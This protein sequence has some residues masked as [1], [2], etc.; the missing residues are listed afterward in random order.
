MPSLGQQLDIDRCPHC[1]VN[2]P[3][4]SLHN[5]LNLAGRSGVSRHW[6]IY[7]CQKCAGVIIAEA[8]SERGSIK[9]IFPS[10]EQIDDSIPQ[11]ARSYLS[12]S[13]DSLHAPAGAIMLAA[14][15]V[16][17]ML[18]EKNYKAGNLY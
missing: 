18:K 1:G 4:V 13:R 5:Y 12:Q 3:N 8:V 9:A 2:S 15:A 6:G 17:A 11:R 14:S 7:S 10:I 16:D